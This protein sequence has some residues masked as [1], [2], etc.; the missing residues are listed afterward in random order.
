MLP[1]CLDIGVMMEQSAWQTL[2]ASDLSQ[3]RPLSP[4]LAAFP[5][6]LSSSPTLPTPPLHGNNAAL[7]SIL[8]EPGARGQRAGNPRLLCAGIR[9]IRINRCDKEAATSGQ[10]A[11]SPLSST[12]CSH[13]FPPPVDTHGIVVVTR[14]SVTGRA[15]TSPHIDIK[16]RGV[17]RC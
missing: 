8:T 12:P 6:L 16:G 15:V 14:I 9:I 2:S 17:R 11:T 3:C 7:R 1:A 13:S 4:P 10:T 5:P